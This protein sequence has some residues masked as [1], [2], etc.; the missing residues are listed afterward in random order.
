MVLENTSVDIP[1]VFGGRSP[2]VAQLKANAASAAADYVGVSVHCAQGDAVCNSAQGVK[3]GQSTPSPTQSPDTLPTEPG[4][5]NGFTAL[6]GHRYIAPQLGAGTPNLSRNGYPVTNGAGNLVD[7]AGSQINDPKLNSP[8]FP[9]FAGISAGQTLAYMADMQESSV[10]I[11][12]GY[13][14]DLHGSH[15]IEPGCPP[16]PEIAL[17]PGDPCYLAQAKAYDAAFDTFFKRLAAD[18]ITPDNSLFV[19]TADEGDHVAGANVGRAIKPTPPACDGVHV[20]C[21]YPAGTFG[22]LSTNIN[23]LL[24]T[25]RNNTTPFSLHSDSAPQFYVTGNPGPTDPN[26]RTLERDVAALTADNPYSG[27]PNEKITNYLADPVEQ[28]I[29]HMVTA[30]PARTPTFSLFAKPD[31]FVH[32]GAANCTAPCVS[33]DKGFAYNH[34]DYAAEINTTW[35]GLVGPGVAHKGVDGLDAAEGPSSAGPNSGQVTVPGSGS[36]GTW[37]DHADIRPTTL[38]LVGLKDDYIN[39]GR[40]LTEDLTRVSEGL[41]SPATTELAAI[42]KQLNSCV[43]LFATSTLIAATQGIESTSPGDRAYT[44]TMEA[45]AKLGARRDRLATK[46]KNELTAAAFDEESIDRSTARSQV[47][48]SQLL[49]QAADRL[50]HGA[51]ESDS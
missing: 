14:S 3:F 42:Y 20:P 18:G 40:V 26:V 47:L 1:K 8:G 4:G 12:Y 21:T 16:P 27:N 44:S 34:G 28:G 10:P 37:A 46:I 45:L 38:Y 9:G 2:E 43:G 23:G 22:E 29:L 49:I 35:L 19:F 48:Q 11:T 32:P 24:K 51:E 31:Y 13:I 50:A 39:D 5:Y 30:D 7:L 36:T 25:Q 6:F 41:E 17:G 33:V 15:S